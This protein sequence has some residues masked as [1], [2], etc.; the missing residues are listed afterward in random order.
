MVVARIPVHGV[1]PARLR[2]PKLLKFKRFRGFSLVQDFLYV[3]QAE[4]LGR[5]A[6]PVLLPEGSKRHGHS[7]RPER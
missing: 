4:G 2:E 6:L 1:D 5:I 3:G 7:R